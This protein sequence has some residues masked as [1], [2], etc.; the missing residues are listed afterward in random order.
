[1]KEVYVGEI[2]E[3]KKRLKCFQ[4]GLK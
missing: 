1:M 4:Y 2:I 3:V